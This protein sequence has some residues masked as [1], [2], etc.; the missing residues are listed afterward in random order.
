MESGMVETN[1]TRRQPARRG[2]GERL[3]AE[4]VEAA[5]RMLAETGDV[6]QVSLRAV[7]REVGIATTSIYLHFRA[8][9]ELVL[10]VKMRYFDEFGAVLRAAEEAAGADPL[11]RVRAGAHA[12]V[13]YG[14]RA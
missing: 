2:E 13:D 11:A 1:V 8:L 10:A 12:Y 7:A 4:I 6:S 3:R 5:S 14:L 9:D